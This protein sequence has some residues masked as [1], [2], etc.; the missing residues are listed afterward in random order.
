VDGAHATGQRFDVA[1][2]FGVKFD[3]HGLVL[4]ESSHRVLN[5]QISGP[6]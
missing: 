2:E 3:R 5:R 1:L 4:H 6:L